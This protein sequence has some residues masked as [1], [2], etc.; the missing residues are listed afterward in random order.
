MKKIVLRE[1]SEGDIILNVRIATCDFCGESSVK[2]V[3]G[4]QK[5]I[6]SENVDICWNCINQLSKFGKKK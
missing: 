3:K 5:E 1:E 4:L 6:E 2:C